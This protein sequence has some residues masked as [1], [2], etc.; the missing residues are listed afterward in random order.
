MTRSQVTPSR[1]RAWMGFRTYRPIAE[2]DSIGVQ[3]HGLV[4]WVTGRDNSDLATKRGKP[5]QDVVLD[6]KVICDY[7]HQR[8]PNL[9][10]S[11][12]LPS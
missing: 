7:L 5:P 12:K 4:C 6:A 11:A 3:S 8:S 10:P 1:S 2:E 9:Q